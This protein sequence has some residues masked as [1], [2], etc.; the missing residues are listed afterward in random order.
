[1][2]P[3][4]A[5]TVVTAALPEPDPA[6][7]SSSSSSHHPGPQARLPR[8][9]LAAQT[10]LAPRGPRH[11]DV[12]FILHLPP[13]N[14]S[15]HR[16]TPRIRPVPAAGTNPPKSRC[17]RLCQTQGKTSFPGRGSQSPPQRRHRSRVHQHQHCVSKTGQPGTGVPCPHRP[18]G[19]GG[20]CI[21]IASWGLGD[22]TAQL[23][24][25]DQGVPIAPWGPGG[26]ASPSLHED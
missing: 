24:H 4:P 1:M 14:A 5:L 9:T 16:G 10:P 26:P 19:T 3:R 17:P 22:P 2:S 12:P 23:L 18:M 13:C 7:P 6:S 8:H 15:S 21:P 25:G 11:T 20:S